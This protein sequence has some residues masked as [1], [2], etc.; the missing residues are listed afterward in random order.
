LTAVP[1]T[2]KVH[3]PALQSLNR[4]LKLPDT[5]APAS[6]AYALPGVAEYVSVGPDAGGGAVTVIEN[7]L[8]EALALPSLTVMRMPEYTTFANVVAGVP[9]NAPV[10]VLKLAQAGLF[11]IENVSTSPSASAAIGVKLYACPATTEPDGVPLMVGARLAGAAGVTAAAY[12]SASQRY[13]V[14]VAALVGI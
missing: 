7:A 12:V 1:S 4:T 3:G 11:W 2:E 6:E 10:E 5:V 9:V 8:V 14:A 13:V